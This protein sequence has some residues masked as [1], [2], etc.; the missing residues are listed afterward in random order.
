MNNKTIAIIAAVVLLAGAGAILL[1]RA[2]RGEPAHQTPFAAHVDADIPSDSTS[3]GAAP[4]LPHATADTAHPGSNPAS[5]ADATLPLAFDYDASQPE[6]D[7]SLPVDWNFEATAKLR[8]GDSIR[9]RLPFAA[10]PYRAIVTDE[11][12]QEGV[13]RITGRLQDDGGIDSWP[14][15]ISLA[16]DG[17]YATAN[18]ETGAAHFTVDADPRGGH[19]RDARATEAQLDHDAVQ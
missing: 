8:P 2:G 3:P 17:K 16:A 5:Q 18:F 4:L 12:T 6:A 13:R 11:T 1:H 14:F 15:S 7:G 19:L 10:Q 9:V